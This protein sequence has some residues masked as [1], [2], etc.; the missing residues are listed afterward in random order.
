MVVNEG[1]NGSS[2]VPQWDEADVVYWSEREAHVLLPLKLSGQY[3]KNRKTWSFF[4][5]RAVKFQDDKHVIVGFCDGT[6]IA[7]DCSTRR[8]IF[9][10]RNHITRQQTQLP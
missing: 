6:C 10:G 1:G 8:R 4:G 9:S 7:A 5:L 2:Q 3:H